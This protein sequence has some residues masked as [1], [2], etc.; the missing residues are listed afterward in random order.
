MTA[1]AKA[2]TLSAYLDERLVEEE[3]R[4]L[5]AHLARCDSCHSRL[6]GLRSVVAGLR[7]L[8]RFSPPSILDQMVARRIALAGKERSF[9]DRLEEGMVGFQ[10]QSSTLS[11][12]CVVIALVLIVYFFLAAV[13]EQQNATIP[14]V[15]ESPPGAVEVPPEVQGEVFQRQ[16]DE[17]V[18][19]GEE[20]SRIR[21]SDIILL[22]QGER[23]VEEGVDPATMTRSIVWDSDVGREL[24][25]KYSWLTALPALGSPVV[26]KLGG[27]VIEGR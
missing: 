23:W 5:E 12:F 15:F 21:L 17:W 9:L 4:E 19:L 20:G 27:E 7:R 25:E 13:V 10:R 18:R 3:T 22:R 8:E 2:E 14:V 16:G 24:L 6:E 1:H 11:I 26:F